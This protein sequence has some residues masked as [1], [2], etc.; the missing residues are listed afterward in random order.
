MILPVPWH[1]ESSQLATAEA[2]RI[3]EPSYFCPLIG[4]KSPSL[5]NVSPSSRN[6]TA[7]IK[8]PNLEAQ[9]HYT[10]KLY[11]AFAADIGASETI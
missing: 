2:C 10:Q 7:T 6:Y 3:D 9:R 8:R 4:T 1:I 11:A 5:N